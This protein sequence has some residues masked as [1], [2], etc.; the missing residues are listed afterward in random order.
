MKELCT[1][2]RYDS[3]GIREIYKYGVDIN[4]PNKINFKQ[5]LRLLRVDESPQLRL[6]FEGL[7]GSITTTIDHRLLLILLMNSVVSPPSRLERLQFSFDILDPEENRMITFDDL[8]MILQGN[9]FAVTTKEVE[10][11]AKLLLRETA[12]SKSVD[13][14]IL[15][16]DFQ[17]LSNKFQGLFFP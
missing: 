9:Y 8:L 16:E 14:P 15:L 17:T 6:I 5:F 13:D 1:K 10:A 7:A 11:K 12:N 2:Y 4:L 3:K